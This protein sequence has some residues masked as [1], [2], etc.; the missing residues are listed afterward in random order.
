MSDLHEDLSA[1]FSAVEPGAAPVEAAML[2]GK[3]IRNRRRAGL[4]AGAVA[5]VA[6]AVVGVPA[7]THDEAL[8]Q[9]TTTH[10]RVTV[11]PPGPHSPAGLIASGLIGNQRWDV[12]VQSP[13][14]SNCEVTGINLAFL[15]CEGGLNPPDAGD[16]IALG[17]SGGG[18]GNA[19]QYFVSYGTVRADV[20]SVRVVLSDGTVLN[21]RPTMVGGRRLVAFAT[22][23]G[24]PVDSLTAYS[25][26]GE[27]ATAIPFNGPAG[28]SEPSFSQWLR[29]G[30]AV[31]GRLS[32]TIESGT[33]NG[34]A[35]RATAYL[36]PW[37]T[38]VVFGG[39][40]DCFSPEQHPQTGAVGG[41]SLDEWGTAAASV[42]YLMVTPKGGIAPARVNVIAV[43]HQKFW[44]IQLSK[45]EQMGGHFTA[46]DAAGK[47]IASGSLLG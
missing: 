14:S 39:D 38:C 22:P 30:Q 33:A 20:T 17:G 25:R 18:T 2:H 4:L 40:T 29:P 1:A 46:Y 3:K 10:I 31:P 23:T 24:V 45:N 26:T 13:S 27:I 43:G 16:P 11:N 44:A 6:A 35:W 5:V 28:D 19:P 34:Q 42:S 9:P 47:L 37:G 12:I 15:A 41:S 7:F 21:P 36:G 8:P 32:G